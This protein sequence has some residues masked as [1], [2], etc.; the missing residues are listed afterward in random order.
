MFTAFLEFIAII[1]MGIIAL[2]E[3]AYDAV[4]EMYEDWMEGR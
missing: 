4:K 3:K 2:C 1:I